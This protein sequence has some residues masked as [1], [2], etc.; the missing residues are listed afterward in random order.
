ME[1]NNF[2]KFLGFTCVKNTNEET[3]YE[4]KINDNMLNPFEALHGG[5][6][7]ALCDE[8]CG[9]HAGLIYKMPV[10]LNANF[11]YLK[12]ALNTKTI[13]AIVHPIKVGKT[14]AVLDVDVYD[15][16][17]ICLC[18]GTFN[19]MEIAKWNIRNT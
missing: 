13:K 8:A 15:D 18:N 12:P 17:D 5:L 7:Y 3:I 16:K 19:Y 2:G 6:L 4:V 10:T 14:I 9:Y 11:N 1:T